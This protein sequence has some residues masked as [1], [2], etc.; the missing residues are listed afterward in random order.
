MFLVQHQMKDDDMLGR[1]QGNR[2]FVGS[3]CYCGGDDMLGRD[4]GNRMFVGS[5][6]C[7]GG[8]DDV[9]F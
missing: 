2:M 7:C 6:C 3:V 1:D 8:D 9:H 5:V 4:Q